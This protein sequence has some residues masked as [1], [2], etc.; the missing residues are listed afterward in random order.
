MLFRSASLEEKGRIEREDA[1]EKA[2]LEDALEEEHETRASLEEKLESIEESHNEII[3]K[4]I[5][6]RDH[7]HAKYKVTKKE[8]ARLNEELAKLSSSIPN[9]NDA[10]DSSNTYQKSYICHNIHRLDNIESTNKKSK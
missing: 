6:E 1:N 4:I 3:A 8:N 5:K 2:S 9:V 7:A 10:C